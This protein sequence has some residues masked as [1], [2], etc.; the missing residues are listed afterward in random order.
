MLLTNRQPWNTGHVCPPV[1]LCYFRQH[2][3]KVQHYN[4]PII[5][6]TCWSQLPPLSKAP[7]TSHNSGTE[8]PG[9]GPSQRRSKQPVPVTPKPGARP[10]RQDKARWSLNFATRTLP[11]RREGE[12]ETG[13][14]DSSYTG[15]WLQLEPGNLAIC[16]F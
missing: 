14:W 12:R 8:V 11:Q 7:Q 4:H 2:V 9:E 13:R 16:A 5:L 15:K 10:G 6:K 3:F 1:T